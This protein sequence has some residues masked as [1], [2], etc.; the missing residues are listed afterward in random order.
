[1]RFS[2]VPAAVVAALTVV[3]AVPA[4][5]QNAGPDAGQ[6]MGL[7]LE[8]SW[9]ATQMPV[10]VTGVAEGPIAASTGL[11]HRGNLR[12]GYDLP[13]GVTPLLGIGIASQSVSFDGDPEASASAMAIAILLEGRYYLKPHKRGLQPFVFG[14]INFTNLSASGQID[15]DDV[16]E[17]ENEIEVDMNDTFGFDLGFGAE[18]KFARSFGI[19]GKWGLAFLTN[20][21][22]NDDR[23]VVST[24]D[25]GTL[26][27]LY[28]AYRF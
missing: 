12:I 8:G 6:I 17:E 28:A 24:F 7:R 4:A 2:L 10:F 14:G 20:A 5:A 26:F 3:T 13:M 23:D 1:M 25:W 16:S 27:E 19:G 21:W 9:V 18:Y 15:G 22:E 11:G